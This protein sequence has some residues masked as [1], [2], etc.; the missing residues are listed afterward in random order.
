MRNHIK[1]YIKK[2]SC[3]QK[4]KHITQVKYGK[5][6]YKKQPDILQNKVIIDF[7]I[8]LLRS[9]NLTIMEKYNVI[10]VIVDKLT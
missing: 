8:K 6:L 5:I 9:K 1:A 2:Y 10:L 7:I 4:N 3:Y